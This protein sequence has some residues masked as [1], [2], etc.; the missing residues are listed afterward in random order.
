MNLE[1]EKNR[2]YEY[3]EYMLIHTLRPPSRVSS[4]EVKLE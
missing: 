3:N 1:T 2:Q 4:D